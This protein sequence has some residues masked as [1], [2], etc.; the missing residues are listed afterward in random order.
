MLV[1]IA[2]WFFRNGPVLIAKF[3][4]SYLELGLHFQKCLPCQRPSSKLSNYRLASVNRIVLHITLHPP[5]HFTQFPCSDRR[6]LD[7]YNQL[8]VLASMWINVRHCYVNYTVIIIY[9][10]PNMK[11]ANFRES[12]V[13]SCLTS[14]TSFLFRLY[15]LSMENLSLWRCCFPNCRGSWRLPPD[16]HPTHISGRQIATCTPPRTVHFDP[17]LQTY[18]FIMI[19]Y[20]ALTSWY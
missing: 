19:F 18:C 20:V 17:P 16:P 13:S 8:C 15:C 10:Q 5:T 2:L 6:V 14:G 11:V 7:Q 9:L 12:E 4:C 1:V 3:E